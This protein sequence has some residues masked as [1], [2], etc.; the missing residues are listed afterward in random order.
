[1]NQEKIGKFIS[2]LRKEKK[3]TQL[4]L[5]EKLRVTDRSVSNWEN[6]KCMPDL[7]LFKPLCEELGISMNE[8]LSGEKL[9]KEDYQERF[10]ENMVNTINYTNKK[11]NQ[12]NSMLGITLLV[13]G[14][15]IT[16]ISIYIF[17]PESSLSSF[18]SIFGGIVALI[19]FSKLTKKLEYYRRVVLNFGFFIIFV[20]I[21]FLLD[22]INV[23]LNDQAPR[24]S[25]D[26]VTIDKTI[27]YDT[28]FYD[29]YRCNINSDDEY[30][31][32]EKNSKYD[33][34]SIINYCKK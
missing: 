13:F 24:F 4:E 7:S 17:P 23:K 32:I 25:K 6:G 9:K 31:T 18:Y 26:I 11:I 5:A 33:N 27:F 19:G 8:L 2:Q 29:V 16:L 30:W 15:L 22:Y 10:E 14:F 12:Q 28:P 21:L 20:A 3:M 1:M 34:E